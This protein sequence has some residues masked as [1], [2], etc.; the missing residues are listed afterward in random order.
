MV[1]K[2]VMATVL[3]AVMVASVSVSA[4]AATTDYERSSSSGTTSSGGGGGGGSSSGGGGGGGR[5][6]SSS[7]SST[8]STSSTPGGSV[9]GASRVDFMGLVAADSSA[10]DTGANAGTWYYNPNTG[11]WKYQFKNGTGAVGWAQLPWTENGETRNL[12]YYFD[13]NGIMLDGNQVI[14][15]QNYNLNSVSNG[16]RGGMAEAPA[17]NAS[18]EGMVSMGSGTSTTSSTNNTSGESSWNGT[19][20]VN[21]SN[22][23]WKFLYNNGNVAVGWNQL[24]WTVNGVTRSDWYYFNEDGS[25]KVGLVKINGQTYYFNPASDG[26]KGAMVTGERDVNG[27]KMNFA[28]SGELLN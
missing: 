19:W 7:S 4:F 6:A 23:D 12:W 8:S 20:Y 15:G 27:K 21:P 16:W 17:N 28:N 22:S 26:F 18:V 13:S 14:A 1:L 25:M 3:M 10:S 9:L 5:A 2:K 24:T 11:D